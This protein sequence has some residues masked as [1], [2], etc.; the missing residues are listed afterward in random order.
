MEKRDRGIW[1]LKKKSLFDQGLLGGIRYL[2]KKEEL[3]NLVVN[4]G[5]YGANEKEKRTK[6]FGIRDSPS[7]LGTIEK[8]ETTEKKRGAMGYSPERGTVGRYGTT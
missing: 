3:R 1:F 2:K 5:K 7:L 8:Y 4:F 6:G